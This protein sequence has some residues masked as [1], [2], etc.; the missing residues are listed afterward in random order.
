MKRDLFTDT[1][2]IEA[3]NS[4][5]SIPEAAQ[6]LG[7]S[8]KSLW[9]WLKKLNIPVERKSYQNYEKRDWGKVAQWLRENGNKPLPKSPKELSKLSGISVTSWYHYMYRRKLMY[10][11]RVK[12]YIDG[13][14]Q[15]HET[16]PNG[17]SKDQGY[18]LD[19]DFYS[20]SAVVTLDDKSIFKIAT[21]APNGY[22]R[23]SD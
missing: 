20:H 7:V 22:R 9:R 23:T 2:L 5:V 13:Y 11:K 12:K 18:S 17:H 21:K 10:Q 14:I 16:Y 6:K 3:Y 19:I 4:S 1:Q 15:T 8:R